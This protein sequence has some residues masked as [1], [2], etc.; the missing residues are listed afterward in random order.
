MT[1]SSDPKI[2]PMPSELALCV[3]CGQGMEKLSQMA[4]PPTPEGT[5]N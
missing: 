5:E 2:T 3:E 1:A 4:R